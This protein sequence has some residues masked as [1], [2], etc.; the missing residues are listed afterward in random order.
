MMEQRYDDR[1]SQ[2]IAFISIPVDGGKFEDESV[3]LGNVLI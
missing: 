2:G 3:I 1:G